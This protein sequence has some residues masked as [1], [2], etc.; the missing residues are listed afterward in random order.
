MLRHPQ[1]R[2]DLLALSGARKQLFEHI[3]V[4]KSAAGLIKLEGDS[5]R[6]LEW[7]LYDVAFV[8]HWSGLGRCMDITGL[9]KVSSTQPDRSQS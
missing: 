9:A 1:A 7:R 6:F 2:R 8:I 5:G 4:P 3:S